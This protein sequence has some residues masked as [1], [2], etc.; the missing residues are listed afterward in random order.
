M[1]MLSV[2]VKKSQSVRKESLH[3]RNCNHALNMQSVS[4]M[5]GNVNV[6]KDLLG[7]D[8]NVSLFATA[9]FT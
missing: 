5:G 6:E 4:I 2:L 9:K 7:M 3:M 8:M 1:N